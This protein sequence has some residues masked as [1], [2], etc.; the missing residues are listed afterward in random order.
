MA[1]G[2]FWSQRR[3]KSSLA[4]ICATVKLPVRRTTSVRVNLPNHSLCQKTS[5]RSR[6]TTLKNWCMYV[7]AFSSTCS[8][9]R[10]GR[11]TDAPLGS[12]ICAVQSPTMST[13]LC[14]SSCSCL[15]FR[16]PTTWPRWMSRLEGSK[17]ILS[18]RGLSCSNSRRNS[19][20]SMIS[21]TPRSMTVRSAS[22]DRAIGHLYIRYSFLLL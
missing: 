13:T 22:C 20:R 10:T 21:A 3:R 17:P 11:V 19:F 14:P 6:S 18:R 9:V 2:R 8:C 1:M 7:W 4:I 12:P 15:S 16:S 5:V